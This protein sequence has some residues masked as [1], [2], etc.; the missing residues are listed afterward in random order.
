VTGFTPHWIFSLCLDVIYSSCGM[1]LPGERE[2]WLQITSVERTTPEIFMVNVQWRSSS[3][4][5]T[6]RFGEL[7]FLFLCN[8]SVTCLHQYCHP[9]NQ[10]QIC[11]KDLTQ[12]LT[13]FHTI[14]SPSSLVAIIQSSVSTDSQTL[15]PFF[16][17][18]CIKSRLSH[19]SKVIP[20]HSSINL[21]C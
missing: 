5:L 15:Y 1:N 20:Y 13:Q 8:N 14:R 16:S 10:L 2:L 19:L 18:I 6:V 4:V 11:Y 9:K 7:R 3:D 21:M 12:L 17:N